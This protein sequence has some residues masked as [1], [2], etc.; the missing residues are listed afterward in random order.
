MNKLF[1]FTSFICL[2]LLV[3][4]SI[5]DPGSS[6]MW[7]ASESFEINLVR[8]SL[9]VFLA[10]LLFTH[11]PRDERLRALVGVVA[12]YISFWA[13]N[14]T[15]LNNVEILDGLSLLMTAISMG[16][17]VLEYSPAPTS[18]KTK[19]KAKKNKRIAKS[20]KLQTA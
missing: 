14:Q 9:M 19:T 15:Y 10:V 20:P 18:T 12:I 4:L 13:T 7:I 1:L 2:G 6:I 5:L 17:A 11:P 16:I 3:C 8:I